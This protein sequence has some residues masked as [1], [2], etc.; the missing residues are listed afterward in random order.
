MDSTKVFLKRSLVILEENRQRHQEVMNKVASMEAETAKWRASACTV[1]RLERLKVASVVVAL[2]EAVRSNHQLSSKVGSVLAKLLRTRLDGD[3]LFKCY[4]DLKEKKMNLA[5]R[6]EDVVMKKY[7]L[8]K[9]VA[10]LEARLKE[11]ESMLEESELR[12]ARERE[13]SKE[14]K[15]ELLIFKKEVVEQH[16]KGFNKAVKQVGFFTKELDL[17]LFDPFKDVK[18]GVLLN[19]K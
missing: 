11:S 9:K 16:E 18:D 19:K 15:E 3:E 6:V 10:D 14:L 1:R 4:K 8:A 13:A 7:E 12:A 5:G 17:G 2:T